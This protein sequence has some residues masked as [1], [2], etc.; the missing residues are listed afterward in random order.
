MA[1]ATATQKTKAHPERTPEDRLEAIVG[2]FMVMHG[3]HVE[4]GPQGNPARDGFGPNHVYRKGDIFDSEYDLLKHNTAPMGG[5][6]KFE[7]VDDRTGLTA[8][9]QRVKSEM[10]RLRGALSNSE[11][12]PGATD[13]LES[14]SVAELKQLAAEEGV[15]I[16]SGVTSQANIIKAIQK[17]T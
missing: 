12:E 17:A 7:R 4:W 8:E 3:C 13:T 9:M 2:T 15:A 11:P 6:N 1:T 10:E 14:M 5:S 16:P